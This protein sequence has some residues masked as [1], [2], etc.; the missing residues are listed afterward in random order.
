LL[1]AQNLRLSAFGH[2]VGCIKVLHDQGGV[3]LPFD[4]HFERT[5]LAHQSHRF[6]MDVRLAGVG[7]PV[8]D[9]IQIQARLGA[10]LLRSCAT[11]DFDGFDETC[12]VKTSSQGK[13]INLSQ[14]IYQ[15]IF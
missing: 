8:N 14:S 11:L 1:V 4:V 5:A 3:S 13:E 9:P 2:V 12:H 6:A 10:E 15:I 7:Y